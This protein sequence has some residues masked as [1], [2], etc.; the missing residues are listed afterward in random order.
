MNLLKNFI[1][2]ILSLLISQFFMYYIIDEIIVMFASSPAPYIIGRLLLACIIFICLKFLRKDIK[3]KN[4]F[5][6]LALILYLIFLFSITLYRGSSISYQ[7]NLKPFAFLSYI[8]EVN[9]S[10]FVAAISINIILLVPLGIYLKIIN[11]KISFSW[12]IIFYS[13][14]II[15]LL[16]FVTRRGSFDIDD[17]M[18]NTLGGFLSY[19]ITGFILNKIKKNILHKSSDLLQYKE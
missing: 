7:Y 11:K 4:D 10:T 13:S 15:E 19:L 12:Q 16:Q 2:I 8:S 18:L 17:L 5:L 3:L 14:L 1:L 9:L 6:N